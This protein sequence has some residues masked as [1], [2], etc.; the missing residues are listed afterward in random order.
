MFDLR[1]I[2]YVLIAMFA[3]AM[4]GFFTREA[5]ADVL[6]IAT[7]RAIM[8]AI[9][10]GAAALFRRELSFSIVEKHIDQKDPK[11]ENLPENLQ[12]KEQKREQK[13]ET[14]GEIAKLG[15]F[16]PEQL[17][18][19]IPYGLFLALASSTFVGG[20]ALTTIANTIFLHNLAPMFAIPLVWVLFREKTSTSVIVGATISV[21]GVA[22][23]SGVSLFHASH[24]TNLRYLFGD[25]LS[26]VSA[27]GYAGVLVWTQLARRKQLPILGT[28]FVAWSVAALV[29]IVICLLFGTMYISFPSALWVL[30]LAFFCTNLPFTLLNE[31]MKRVSASMTSLLSMSEV[32]FATI[33]GFFVY[34]EHLAPIGW[35]GG[36]LLVIGVVY[37]FFQNDVSAENSE[38]Q[39]LLNSKE[40]K[41]Q[42][43]RAIMW[44]AFINISFLTIFLLEFGYRI[45]ILIGLLALLSVSKPVVSHLLDGRKEWFQNSLIGFGVVIVVLSLSN[46]SGTVVLSPFLLFIL[47]V[48]TALDVILFHIGFDGQE[49][50]KPTFLYVLIALLAVSSFFSFWFHQG[51]YI[52]SWLF[53]IFSILYAFDIFRVS[54]QKNKKALL[55]MPSIK[56]M[57]ISFLL[58]YSVG[59]IHIIPIGHQGLVQRLG[60]D[61]HTV[62][63]GLHVRLPPPF[64]E[65]HVVDK[66][67][68]QTLEVFEVGKQ[69]FLCSDQSLL[70]LRVVVQYKISNVQKFLYQ[71][72]NPQDILRIYAQTTLTQEIRQTPS[73][74]LFHQRNKLSQTWL[75]ALR[76]YIGTSDIGIDVI[77][78]EIIELSVPSAV[79][80]SFLDVVSAIED[81]AT[82]I[83]HAKSYAASSLPLALGKAVVTN[84]MAQAEQQEIIQ[85]SQSWSTQFSAKARSS[86][87][88]S[89]LYLDWLAQ[90]IFYSLTKKNKIIIQPD[91]QKTAVFV[92]GFLDNIQG[93]ELQSIK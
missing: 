69:H 92:E 65:I 74:V 81:K 13:E 70:P 5:N 43:I 88:L 80:D 84:E 54:L 93:I 1:S 4:M 38:E 79:R 22:F 33:L 90:D 36:I 12:E 40:V 42:N 53:V 23:I 67:K 89:H 10:F 47:L 18:I 55:T 61:V 82:T 45:G 25:F 31:G 14:T 15:V 8:V 78:L 27:V 9:L 20:Y 50:E 56:W 66:E 37:P 73:D 41:I 28:L 48:V 29:L 34:G 72:Q 11:K 59:G 51:Q 35:I 49:M 6:T 2:L 39:P 68:I 44:L 7:W 30:G 75:L 91:Q 3:F 87:D 52:S 57:G 19:S 64:E 77:S 71:A 63:S 60:V 46:I 26:L 85:I 58:L 83:N 76:E 32:L 16:H 86:N 24:F 17:K 21:F 62:S